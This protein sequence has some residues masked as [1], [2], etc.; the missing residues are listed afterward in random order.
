M[1]RDFGALWKSSSVARRN[2]MAKAILQAVYVNPEQKRIVGL[3]PK[4]TFLAPVLAMAK[5]R[6][7]AGRFARLL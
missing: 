4:E 5:R 2:G 3:L 1:L 7:R 6:G